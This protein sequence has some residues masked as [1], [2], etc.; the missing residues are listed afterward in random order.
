MDQDVKYPL[1]KKILSFGDI[2]IILGIV[3]AIF[4]WYK[5]KKNQ[6]EDQDKIYMY[7]G[8]SKKLIELSNDKKGALQNEIEKHTKHGFLNIH[9]DLNHVHKGLLTVNKDVNK[10]LGG[11]RNLTAPIRSAYDKQTQEVYSRINN[12]KI[13]VTY[14]LHKLRD[15]L[16]RSV[17]GFNMVLHT[18]ETIR[19][20]LISTVNSPIKDLALAFFNEDG[21]PGP[22]F[23]FV[24][25]AGGLM[26]L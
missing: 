16:K 20:S 7:A 15:T 22:L 19:L 2:L 8:D 5:N 23:Y 24:A 9:D 26:G 4:Y 12:F 14:L 6:Q 25:G 18:I 3:L 10:Y 17:S 21:S 1:L 13:G 11:I